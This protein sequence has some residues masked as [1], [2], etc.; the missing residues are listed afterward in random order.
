VPLILETERFTVTAHDKPH[1]SRENGGHVKVSPKAEYAHR[2]E[3]P[4]DEAASLMHLTMVTGEA[5]TNVMRQKGLDVVRINYQ[6]NGNW[7]YLAVNPTPL[8]LHV[9]LYVRTSH[10]KHPEH[11][12]RFQAFP[13]A[14]VFPPRDS[15]Y[16]DSFKPLTTEDCEDIKAE[17]TRLLTTNKYKGLVL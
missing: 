8:H 3:M 11:D 16:Y 4:L 6:D 9:H 15:G 2:Q 1:H 17:I 13:E 5:V 7:S 10:E 12:P 14:L